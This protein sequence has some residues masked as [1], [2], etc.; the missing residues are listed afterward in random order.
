MDSTQPIS[1]H[2][3]IPRAARG[4]LCA[5]LS[6][7][8]VIACAPT[9]AGGV[10]PG[11]PSSAASSCSGVAGAA[12][13]ASGAA[14]HATTGVS[15]RGAAGSGPL[16]AL[17]TAGTAA[18]VTTPPINTG[19]FPTTPPGA[20]T[21]PTSGGTTPP[22]AGAAGRGGTLP[23][24]M[25]PAAAG[26][27]ASAGSAGAG[28]GNT[29]VPADELEMLRQTCV[30]EINMYRATLTA[31]M[32]KPLKRAS[33]AQE[34]CS[35]MGAQMDGDSMQAHGSAKAGLCQ[36]VGLY[37]EDTCPGWGVGG[38]SGNA[39]IADALKGCLKSMWEEGEPPVSR[40]ECQQ[41]YQNCFLKYGHYLNMSDPN[42]GSVA[43]SFYKMK[44]GQYWM[45]QD[46][47]R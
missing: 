12:C 9:S 45:N 11:G 46:F 28:A 1:A 22:P 25:M 16:V 5:A 13:V 44:S 31:N 19:T 8:F 33:A 3:S 32:L 4:A 24:G 40:A 23:T 7:L 38:F 30:D 34:M 27:S 47:A 39:T 17:P 26:G 37:S 14:G 10:A 42:V 15:G 6:S 18:N 2:S 20:G 36:K 21:T 43:C 29:G 35:D 41:D